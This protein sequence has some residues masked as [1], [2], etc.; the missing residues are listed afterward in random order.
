MLASFGVELAVLTVV[1]IIAAGGIVV[2]TTA[3]RIRKRYRQRRER[4]AAGLQ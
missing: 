4:I 1:L 3:I 2:L